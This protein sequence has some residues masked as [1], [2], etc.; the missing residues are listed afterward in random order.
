M[1]QIL[2]QFAGYPARRG[3]VEV[4]LRYGLR[5][6]RDGK[7]YCAEIEIPP[8]K[9]ARALGV[10]RRVVIETARSIADNAELLEVFSDLRPTAFIGNGA[11]KLGFDVIQIEANSHAP[12]IVAAVSKIIAN[13]GISIR[14]IVAD[15]PDIY[16]TPR[17]TVITEKKI[18]GEIVVK[19]RKVKDIKRISIG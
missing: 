13:S 4:L 1:K 19:L 14:Q 17:L 18:P 16:P 11:S 2:G 7:I 5:V 10:D 8:A 6:T 15:D 12:G 3:V 9:V